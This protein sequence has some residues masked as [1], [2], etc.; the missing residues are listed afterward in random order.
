MNSAE[1]GGVISMIG[2][3][4]FMSKNCIFNNNNATIGGTIFIE[5]DGA[6]EINNSTFV[7]NYSKNEGG[8]IHCIENCHTYLLNNTYLIN[9]YAVNQGG[10]GSLYYSLLNISE[11][12]F[13]NNKGTLIFFV[14]FF[15]LKKSIIAGKNSGLGG[16]F[17]FQNTNVSISNSDFSCNQATE[18][19]GGAI[20]DYSETKYQYFYSNNN[21]WN[22]NVASEGSMIMFDGVM[23]KI[24][25][26]GDQITNNFALEGST[27]LFDIDSNIDLLNT[28]FYNN[29]YF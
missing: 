12:T 3:S 4:N 13:Y 7:E 21:L 23:K 15:F 14:L 10:V 20:Y 5:K 22:Y 17:Y 2:E 25:F 29:R 8:V 6:T 27:L 26:N 11:T 19:K 9:N 18:G 1:N 28:K 16:S 24:T